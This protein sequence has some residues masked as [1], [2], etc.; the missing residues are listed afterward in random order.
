MHRGNTD[1]TI[2]HGLAGW[3]RP[4]R[5]SGLLCLWLCLGSLAWLGCDDGTCDA[6]KWTSRCTAK[7]ELEQCLKRKAGHFRPRAL[8]CK[9]GR[10]CQA[11]GAVAACIARPATTCSEAGKQTCKG[12]KRWSCQPLADGSEAPLYEHLGKGCAIG[13]V[14][15]QHDRCEGNAACRGPIGC[16]GPAKERCQSSK[17]YR[18]SGPQP[19][20]C[21][22]LTGRPLQASDH[23]LVPSGI[24]YWMHWTAPCQYDEVCVAGQKGVACVAK[25]AERCTKKAAGK[26]RCVKGKS[27]RCLETFAEAND[28]KSGLHWLRDRTGDR[29]CLQQPTG[30]GT[31][32]P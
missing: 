25:P 27:L 12:S 18:C 28:T 8:P 26:R 4:R 6:E 5:L 1:E 20:R 10:V 17:R 2:R 21:Q 30:R 11:S 3:V 24:R 31:S 19:Q 9:Q 7:G 32:S 15:V 22:E 14:C 23:R 16:A 13:N 29:S